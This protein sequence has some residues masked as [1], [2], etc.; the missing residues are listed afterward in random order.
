MAQLHIRQLILNFIDIRG[1]LSLGNDWAWVLLT[2]RIL[3]VVE[4]EFSFFYSFAYLGHRARVAVLKPTWIIVVFL[5][6]TFDCFVAQVDSPCFSHNLLETVLKSTSTALPVFIS[7]FCGF[8]M[9]RPIGLGDDP[10]LSAERWIHVVVQCRVRSFPL[11]TISIISFWLCRIPTIDLTFSKLV[12]W[13]FIFYSG[14]LWS[15]TIWPLFFFILSFLIVFDDGLSEL[16]LEVVDY[17]NVV[18]ILLSF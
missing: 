11:L 8:G 9:K 4:F 7:I 18:E 14:N 12:S 17:V 15:A 2:R 5:S 16:F 10:A 3:V 13:C 6:R 1:K